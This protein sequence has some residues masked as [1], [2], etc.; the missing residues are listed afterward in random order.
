[1]LRVEPELHQE[2][3][4]LAG[5]LGISLNEY[6]KNSLTHAINRK[7]DASESAE[8]LLETKK[9]WGSE[10]RG[11]VLFGSA[12]RGELRADS[13]ID[14]LIVLGQGAKVTRGNY[15]LWDAE[16]GELADEHFG[17]RVV[18]PH[19]VKLPQD[20]HKVGS[21][22]LECAIDGVVLFEEGEIITQVLRKI[23]EH[24]AS[25]SVVRKLANGHPYWVKRSNR[26]E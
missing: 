25:G 24:I 3:R 11:V 13:D 7:S 10:L 6:C 9:I 23:R 21:I 14:L 8:W 1:M 16:V 18:S 22:W 26:A 20:S 5:D 19:F 17:R 12:A 2:L 4:R 15:S